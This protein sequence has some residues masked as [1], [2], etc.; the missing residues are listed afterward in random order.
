MH[1]NRHENQQN[2]RPH[3][4]L[5]N[6]KG[7]RRM[8]IRFVVSALRKLLSRIE[9]Y[10]IFSLEIIDSYSLHPRLII[11]WPQNLSLNDL[12]IRIF[13]WVY[14][15]W[16]IPRCIITVVLLLETSI[17]FLIAS[18]AHFRLGFRQGYTTKRDFID[19][20]KISQISKTFMALGISIGV[21]WL[22]SFE[23]P[24]W[25]NAEN[26]EFRKTKISK[27]LIQSPI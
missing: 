14:R 3:P 10:S 4:I 24:Y 17:P 6:V 25:Q 22:K 23:L 7:W 1:E 11:K 27:K 5:P 8:K 12:M 15:G 16:I 20:G 9:N 26:S 13:R 19:A 2:H 18:S 21:L